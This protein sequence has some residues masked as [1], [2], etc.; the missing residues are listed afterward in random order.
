MTQPLNWDALRIFLVVMRAKSLRQAAEKLH[1][2][3]PTIRRKVEELE[4]T[5]GLTLFLRRSN[6]L[7]PTVEAMELLEKAEH[8]EASVQAFQRTA[9][10]ADPKLSGPIH[11]TIPDSSMSELI[12]PSI[13]AFNRK[14]PDIDLFIETSYDLA[15]L[16]SREADIAV[17]IITR[18]SLPDGELTGRKVAKTYACKYG[19]GHQWL[20]WWGP[21]RDKEWKAEF[22]DPDLPSVGGLRNIYMQRAACIEG[23]GLSILPCYFADPYLERKSTP[24]YTAD[25]WVLLHPDMRKKPRLRLLR[26]TL[27]EALRALQPVLSGEQLAP[28]L[29]PICEVRHPDRGPSCQAR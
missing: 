28:Q 27:I 5:L 13:A 3:H 4:Q 20:G 8:V 16:S 9:H 18:G 7:H 2:S 25:L 29:R 23:M 26:D 10:N 24:V 14:W 1:V 6:G 11:L 12:M 22:G 17:R 21:E 15:D 19:E